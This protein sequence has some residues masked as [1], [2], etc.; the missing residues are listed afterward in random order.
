[1]ES[2]IYVGMDVHK[3]SY[4]LCCYDPK[5]DLFFSEMQIKSE[6]KNVVKY[7]EH[8][9][10]MNDG[11]VT[12]CGYEAGPTGFRLCRE[13]QK[14]GF[15]CVVMAPTSIAKSAKDRLVKTDRADAKMLAKV[16][17][18]KQYKEV[19]LPTEHIESIKE[20]VRLR[21]NVHKACKRAKQ[22]LLSFLLNQGFHYPDGG[23]S[24]YWTKSFFEWLKTINF[25]SDYL[26]YCFEEY[27][28]EVTRQIQRLSQMDKKLK[29][30]E[31]DKEI[32]DGVSKLRCVCGID[33]IVAVG[34]VAEVGDFKRF[35][36]AEKFASYTGL[37]PGRHSSGLSDRS[38]G[39]TKQG[40][41]HLR[42]LL[43]EAAKSV[44]RAAPR[45]KKSKRLIARQEG[46]PAEIINYAD[47][48]GK[49]IR[50]KMERLERRGVSYN[51]ATAACARELACFVWGMMTEN[52]A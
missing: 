5:R 46:S 14:K 24:R 28:S 12:L 30:L 7:L 6:T 3:D 37:C 43:V 2:I 34:L 41:R 9:L 4:S 38:G 42:K 16:L 10:K 20:I 39:I 31:D 29:E 1:M 19:A 47:K 27:L 40:N 15:A 35:S 23:S 13:L 26:R 50:N 8:V 21:V 45:G 25:A 44:K 36:T 18:A 48:A 51:K 33:T 52:I 17:A 11:A 22:N 49:R 32:A